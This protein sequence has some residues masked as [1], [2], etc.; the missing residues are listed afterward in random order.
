MFEFLERVSVIGQSYLGG[1]FD[2]EGVKNNFTLVYEILDEI[3]DF[4]VCIAG[5][6]INLVPTVNRN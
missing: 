3:C 1:K 4:G 6:S 5:L 2:E